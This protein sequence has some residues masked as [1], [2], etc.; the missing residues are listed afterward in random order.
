MPTA[1]D[2]QNQPK[3][4]ALP[5]MTI[6]DHVLI[7]EHVRAAKCGNPTA[8]LINRAVKPEI[9]RVVHFCAAAPER[10]IE[11]RR[12]AM[13]YLKSLA[14]KLEPGRIALAASLPPMSP[15]RFLH[16]PLILFLSKTINF[17]DTEFAHDLAAG[18]PTVGEFAAAPKPNFEPRR[19]AATLTYD[20]W[21]EG[22]P[23]RNMEVIERVRASAESVHAEE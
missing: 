8:D 14:A 12:E 6:G 2:T 21:K 7:E 3:G 20:Q 17:P 19:T 16:F 23:D 11:R 4:K 5:S 10:V 22:L 15:A 18:I 13:V 1:W 9:K